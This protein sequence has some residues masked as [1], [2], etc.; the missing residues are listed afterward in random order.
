MDP[1]PRHRRTGAGRWKQKNCHRTHGACGLSYESCAL[2]LFS[3]FEKIFPG[4]LNDIHIN[5]VGEPEIAGPAEANTRNAENM[6]FLQFFHELNIV[7]D[8]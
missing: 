3:K 4:T 2:K 7:G 8:W 1:P 6:V 5:T